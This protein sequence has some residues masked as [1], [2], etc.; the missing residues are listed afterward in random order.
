MCDDGFRI[1][2]FLNEDLANS[3][4]VFCEHENC[5]YSQ[6]ITSILDVYLEEWFVENGY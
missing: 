5:T 4:L 2:V 6:A 1:S 3:L